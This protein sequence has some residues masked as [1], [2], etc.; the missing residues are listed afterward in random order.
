MEI[1]YKALQQSKLAL[2]SSLVARSSRGV[3]CDLYDLHTY[4]GEKEM[5]MEVKRV[6]RHLS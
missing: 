1:I 5:M 6:V 4:V 2:L 3:V